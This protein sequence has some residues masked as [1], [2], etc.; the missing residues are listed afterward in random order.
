MKVAKILKRCRVDRPAH[1]RLDDCDPGEDFGLARDKE[2]A[3]A[4][5]ADGVRRLSDLQE[6]LYAQDRWAVLVVLQAMDAAG[7]DSAIK[8]VMS[9]INPQGCEVHPFKAPTEEELQHGFLWRAVVRLP[10]RGRIGIFNRSY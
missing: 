2:G 7:K 3:K 1:F 10:G 4:M 9:G 8:H 6:R 5:L